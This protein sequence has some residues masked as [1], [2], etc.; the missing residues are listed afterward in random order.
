MG[1]Q[2]HTHQTHTHRTICSLFMPADDKVHWENAKMLSTVGESVHAWKI[3]YVRLQSW[4][5]WR[6]SL[7]TRAHTH[8]HADRQTH[9]HLGRKCG[10]KTE[11]WLHCVTQQHEPTVASRMHRQAVGSERRRKR[12]HKVRRERDG[13]EKDGEE[14]SSSVTASLAMPT[15]PAFLWSKISSPFLSNYKCMWSV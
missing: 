15:F 6:A 2:T 9:T 3:S 5:K 10:A 1:S 4:Q 12:G 7:R 14:R 13:P 11:G 8:K